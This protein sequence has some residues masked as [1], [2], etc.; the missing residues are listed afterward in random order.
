MIAQRQF[1]TGFFCLAVAAALVG[2]GKSDRGYVSGTV[3]L[4]GQPLPAATVE[5]QPD[6]GS[7]SIGET[8]DAGHYELAISAAE[9]GA[10]VGKHTV[11]VSTYRIEA[12]EDGT[13]EVIPEKVPSSF[14]SESAN[15]REVKPGRQTIDIEIPSGGSK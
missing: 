6:E 8:D 5:F 10:V 7:P 14:N 3:T 12:H 1:V 9:K 15:I 2:C 11:R 13:R 4:D